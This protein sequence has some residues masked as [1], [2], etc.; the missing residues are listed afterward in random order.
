MSASLDIVCSGLSQLLQAPVRIATPGDG[1]S[2]NPRISVLSLFQFTHPSSLSPA[3][4]QARSTR[5][6]FNIFVKLLSNQ[7]ISLLVNPEDTIGELMDRIEER[8]G[9]PADQIRLMSH[10]KQLDKDL[11]IADLGIQAGCTI[12]LLFRLNGGHQGVN[13]GQ[14]LVAYDIDPDELDP[15][16]DFDFTKVSDGGEKYMRGGHEYQRPYGWNRLAI[17][18]QGAYGDD[19]WL[20]PNGIRTST[21][22]GEWPVS[23]HGTKMEHVKDILK[24]GYIIGPRAKH[25]KGTYSSPS[26][27]MVADMRYAQTYTHSDGKTYQLAFQNR[28]NPA[29]GHLVVIDKSKTGVGADFWISPKQDIINGKYDVRPYGMLTREYPP[30]Y[31]ASS[32]SWCS[33]M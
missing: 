8:E 15:T 21:S 3:A 12:F 25:G 1:S 7:T 32:D 20:G 13:K 27:T 6:N 17:K 18:V 14:D 22:H 19:S 31:P 28:V 2:Q 11:T 33:V 26:L 10:T 9:I 24:D 5:G 29:P 16:Y 23:Y 30:P 4:R